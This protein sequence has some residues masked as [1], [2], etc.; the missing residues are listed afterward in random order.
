[1]RV[2]RPVVF[3][4]LAVVVAGPALA[5]PPGGGRGGVGGGVLGLL[6]SK[7]VREDVKITDDQAG[8]LKDWQRD[9]APKLREMMQEKMQGID[10]SEWREKMPAIMAEISKATYKE[11][12]E[13]LKPEQIKRLKQVGGLQALTT[14]DAAATLKLTD[15]QKEKLKGIADDA[16]KEM[17]DLSEEY[18]G[19]YP[20]QRPTDP[21]KAKEFDKK[22]GKITKDATDAAMK[23]MTDDQKKAHKELTGDP[24]DVAKVRTESMGQGKKKKKDD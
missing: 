11:L 10:R 13:V 2:L 12:G 7:T 18:G 1:M 5:Q 20:G 8:K 17:R 24:I 6:Q 19:R 3:A 16:G 22:A 23:L 9:Y 14:P 15:D 21:E 4:A